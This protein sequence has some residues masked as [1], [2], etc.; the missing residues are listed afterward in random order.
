MEEKGQ[1]PDYVDLDDP[2][3]GEEEPE[4]EPTEVNAL[5]SDVQEATEAE[6]EEEKR[7]HGVYKE[8][9]IKS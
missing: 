8:P 2:V 1:R 3:D 4:D 5:G 6:L 9:E 7:E